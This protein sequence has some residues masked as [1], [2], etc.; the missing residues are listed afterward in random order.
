MGTYIFSISAVAITSAVICILTPE[1]YSKL[2]SFISALAIMAVILSPLKFFKEI[3]VPEHQ[4]L[5]FESDNVN[6]HSASKALAR[7]VYEVLC[8]R[9]FTKDQILS[10]TIED[11][12]E[13]DFKPSKIKI[14]IHNTEAINILDIQKDLTALYGINVIINE[15]DT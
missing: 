5:D 13:M 1:K 8:T 9:Y 7:S 4:V 2:V 14:V 11:N 6:N 10:I 3:N 15:K 12:E